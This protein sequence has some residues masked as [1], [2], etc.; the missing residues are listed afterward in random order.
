MLSEHR[1]EGGEERG[2]ETC[3][4]D[5]LDLDNRVRGTGP[6]WDCRNV[7]AKGSVVDLV[8]ENTEEGGRLIDRVELELGLDVDDEHGSHNGEE[9]A[10]Q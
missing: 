5:R 1:E 3:V 6:L 9:T 4:E 8:D 10:L 7:I 2:G